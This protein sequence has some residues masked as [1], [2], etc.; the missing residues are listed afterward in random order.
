MPWLPAP[1]SSHQ[2]S[3][4]SSHYAGWICS[5]S[6]EFRLLLHSLLYFAR[7]FLLEFAHQ[8][9][10]P[11][12][13][14]GNLQDTAGRELVMCIQT[15][16]ADANRVITRATP[17]I[18]TTTSIPGRIGITPHDAPLLVAKQPI[19]DRS[20]PPHDR[21]ENLALQS[22]STHLPRSAVERARP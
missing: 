15:C 21:M 13:Q 12:G 22:G 7:S 19:A 8:A 14:P 6:T 16:L 20:P 9:P 11:N 4:L 18:T 1:K 2:P 3:T 17:P 10:H 5:P